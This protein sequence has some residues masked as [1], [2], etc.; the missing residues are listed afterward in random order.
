MNAIFAM[1]RS[2]VA[3]KLDIVRLL[4][5]FASARQL[6]ARVARFSLNE[7]FSDAVAGLK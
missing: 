5:V 4:C 7:A 1:Q 6:R 3:L 2:P